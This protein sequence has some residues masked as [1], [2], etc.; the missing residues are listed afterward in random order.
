MDTI[1]T[2]TIKPEL[3]PGFELTFEKDS[4]GMYKYNYPAS[5]TV[6]IGNAAKEFRFQETSKYHSA[7]Y[8]Y[9]PDGTRTLVKDSY[10]E[11]IVGVT[12]SSISEYVQLGIA[13]DTTELD[14][15]YKKALTHI[16]DLQRKA[17]EAAFEEAW[18]KSWIHRGEKEVLASKKRP[19]DM[20]VV[21]SSKGT[22]DSHYSRTLTLTYKEKTAT[23][24]LES[25]SSGRYGSSVTRYGLNAS[26]IP[27][28]RT[29]YYRTIDMAIAKFKSFVDEKIAVQQATLSRNEREE[30]E[31]KANKARFEK[32]FGLDASYTTERKWYRDHH[33]R[34]YGEGYME[35]TYWL[36]FNGKKY[37]I[38]E[39]YKN[40]EK[41][42]PTFV[43][44]G[45]NE[46]T[47]EKVV[48]IIKILGE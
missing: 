34:S 39:G 36:H 40:S 48:A 4:K 1:T 28:Y 32:L 17:K 3:I 10:D 16:K 35:T 13:V 43:F 22:L 24:T 45:F 38:A 6:K 27:G 23:L 21:K 47:P 19:N 20:T 2:A 44:G 14:E 18:E 29:K 42:N 8:A 26:I 31:R 9:A 12:E 15:M 5:L 25:V 46:L 37:R 11:P 33:G 30:M 7:E 41:E